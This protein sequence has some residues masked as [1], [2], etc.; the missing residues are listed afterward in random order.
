MEQTDPAPENVPVFFHA[1]ASRDGA[2]ACIAM[3]GK[4]GTLNLCTVKNKEE[5][6]HGKLHP[7]VLP[8]G[9]AL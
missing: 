7:D 8:P 5:E 1:F 3:D 6:Y 9:Y 4:P 2:F